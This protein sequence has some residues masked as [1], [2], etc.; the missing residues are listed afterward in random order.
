L[1]LGNTLIIIAPNNEEDSKKEEKSRGWGVSPA[2]K[3]FNTP[4]KE[5]K[6]YAK[7]KYKRNCEK[8]NR[9]RV[10]AGNKKY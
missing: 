6:P 1:C 9:K 3:K 4:R 2:R 5:V 10:A 8:C 7:N